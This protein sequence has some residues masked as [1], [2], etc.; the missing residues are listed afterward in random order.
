MSDF[1]QFSTSIDHLGVIA[2]ICDDIGISDIIDEFIGIHHNQTVSCGQATKA[3][4]LNIL[5]IFMR[6][7]YLLSK[8]LDGKPVHRLIAENLRAKDFTDDVLGR[9][10]DKLYE[11]DM[12]AIFLKISSVAFS[13]YCD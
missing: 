5:A 3:M 10:L 9:T 13:K 1:E 6:P 11:H 12:E 7:L 2:V 4:I 8:Y